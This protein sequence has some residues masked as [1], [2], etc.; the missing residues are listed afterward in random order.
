MNS[1]KKLNSEYKKKI[2]ELKNHNKYYFELD[3][4]KISDAKYDELKKEVLELEKKYSFLKK[5]RTY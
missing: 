4:P 3:K 2:Q 5:K 1:K